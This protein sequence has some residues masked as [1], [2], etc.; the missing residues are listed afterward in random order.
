LDFPLA[1]N[2]E[3]TITIKKKF[4][5]KNIIV[6]YKQA[7]LLDCIKFIKYSTRIQEYYLDFLQ[8]HSNIKKSELVYA[9]YNFQ[10]IWDKIQATYFRWYFN[11]KQDKQEEWM[12]FNAYIT[13]IS[14]RIHIEPI[15]LLWYTLEQLKWM[16]EWIIY[17][18]QSQEDRIK[19]SRK[20]DRENKMQKLTN[21]EQNKIKEFLSSNN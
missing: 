21:E 5:K 10:A 1:E 6:K 13:L 9:L 3:L 18:S 15:K 7:S 20:T 12:P 8:T 14:E 19:N 11:N 16:T 17:N 2:F 4:W